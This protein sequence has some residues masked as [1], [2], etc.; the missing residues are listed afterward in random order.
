M[1]AGRRGPSTPV[2]NF[3]IKTHTQSSKSFVPKAQ[4][5][6]INKIIWINRGFQSASHWKPYFSFSKGIIKEAAPCI[7]LQ[8]ITA[9]EQLEALL[10]VNKLIFRGDRL[11]CSLWWLSTQVWVIHSVA[12]T[13]GTAYPV[14]LSILSNFQLISSL[15]SSHYLSLN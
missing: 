14:A 2:E 13:L 12:T 6:Y 1:L 4:V 3:A 11:C 7:P 10:E 5:A 8:S 9:N 15:F